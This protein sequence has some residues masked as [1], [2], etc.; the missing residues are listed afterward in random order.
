VVSAP[1]VT[2]GVEGR[3]PK[4]P[5]LIARRVTKES[6]GIRVQ[7]VVNRSKTTL[8][9]QTI[10]T[11]RTTFFADTEGVRKSCIQGSVDI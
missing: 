2:G 5:D 3:Q 8:I 10:R 6:R 7:N 1:I 9:V 11:P 4:G